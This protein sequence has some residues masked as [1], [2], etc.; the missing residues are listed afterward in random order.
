MLSSPPQRGSSVEGED[1]KPNVAMRLRESLK[2]A[3]GLGF[4]VRFV[5]LDGESPGW[6]IAGKSKMAFLD[7]KATTSDQ[8]AQ[9]EEILADFSRQLA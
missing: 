9:L 1:F 6:C 7:L 8:L 3:K 2:T 5:T 4:N